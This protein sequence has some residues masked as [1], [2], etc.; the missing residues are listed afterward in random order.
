MTENLNVFSLDA[1]EHQH[2]LYKVYK[3]IMEIKSNP[4]TAPIY[5]DEETGIN[6]LKI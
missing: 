2:N 5:K 6:S 3:V 4:R 1:K